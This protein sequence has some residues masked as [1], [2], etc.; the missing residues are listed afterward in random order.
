MLRLQHLVEEGVVVEPALE[1]DNGAGFFNAM[2]I[3]E[4]FVGSLRAGPSTS[5]NAA[6]YSGIRS[7][8]ILNVTIIVNGVPTC[9]PSL[10]DR[11]G[12]TNPSPLACPVT[13]R[14]P[15]DRRNH[16]CAPRCRPA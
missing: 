8:S 13:R 11:C 4:A 9:I 10:L 2:W 15:P 1:K 16:T 6:R 12:S 5:R 7:G 3:E 14:T